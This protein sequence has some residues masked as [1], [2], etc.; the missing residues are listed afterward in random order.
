M[1]KEYKEKEP[2]VYLQMVN[3]LNNGINHAYLFNTNRNLYGEKMI[4]A[5][6][7]NIMCKEHES[8]DEN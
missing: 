5:F 4:L 6:I 3:A 2:I 8:E 7:K 1:L